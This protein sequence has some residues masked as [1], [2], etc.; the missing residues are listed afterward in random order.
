MRLLPRLQIEAEHLL[1]LRD[2]ENPAIRAE[3]MRP[4]SKDFFVEGRL[5]VRR[6]PD[7]QRKPVGESDQEATIGAEVQVFRQERARGNPANLLISRETADGDDSL[8]V[9]PRVVLVPP[10]IRDRDGT[11]KR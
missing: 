9:G 11:R 2:G 10:V 5:S 1:L 6:A 7:A 4:A 3:R 8:G